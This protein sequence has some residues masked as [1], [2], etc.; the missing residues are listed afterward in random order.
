[1][2]FLDFIIN[3]LLIPPVY[4]RYF[5]NEKLGR[6]DSNLFSYKIIKNKA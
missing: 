6:F 3:I 5:V 1:M 2:I 4:F